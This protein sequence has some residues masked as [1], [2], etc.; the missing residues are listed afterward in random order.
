[1]GALSG[2]VWGNG[3]EEEESGEKLKSEA[4]SWEEMGPDQKVGGTAQ[5]LVATGVKTGWN[6]WRW[7][8]CDEWHV[9]VF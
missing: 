7:K 8:R 9:C 3:R 2:S 4:V 1:M 6:E 5:M